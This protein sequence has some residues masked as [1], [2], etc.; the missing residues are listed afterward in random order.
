M[1]K[2]KLEGKL[3]LNKETITKLNEKELNNFIGGD[4]P[5]SK[6][7]KCKLDNRLSYGR[8]CTINQ[9]CVVDTIDTRGIF[10][11]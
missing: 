1:K 4:R 8:W 10:C 9:Q 5:Q 7:L 11:G 2:I 6:G 3:N